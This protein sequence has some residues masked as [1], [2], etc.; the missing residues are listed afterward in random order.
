MIAK[1][2]NKT[3][4]LGILLVIIIALLGWLFD[5]KK[6]ETPSNGTKQQQPQHSHQTE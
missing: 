4:P 2:S 6:N 1:P 3:I 5:S